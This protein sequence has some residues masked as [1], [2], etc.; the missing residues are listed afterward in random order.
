MVSEHASPLAVLGGVDAGG[1]NVHVADL[2]AALGRLGVEVVVHTRRDDPSLPRRVPFAPGVVVDHVDAGPAEPIPKDELLPH[3]AAFAADLA[4]R[5]AASRPDVVHAHFWMSGLAALRRRPAARHP[6]GAH[7]PR[8]RRGEAAP[9][10]RRRHQPA[11][12][13]RGRADARSTRRPRHR[14]HAPTSVASSSAMGGP[15]GADRG[16]PVRRRP[17]PLPPRRP[18]RAAAGRRHRIVVR[19]P[20][21]RAQGHRQRH[22]GRSPDAAR[23]RAGRRRRSAGGDARR[24][25]RGPAAAGGWRA[26]SA[27]TT[28]SRLL[29]AVAATDVPATAALGRRRGLLSRGTSR[30]AWSPSRPWPAACPWWPR[31]SAAWPRRVVDGVTGLL[32]PPRAPAA[33]ADGAPRLLDDDR[34]RAARWAAAGVRAGR[35]ATAGTG[36]PPR[37]STS[38]ATSSRTRPAVAG[39]SGRRR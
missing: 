35:S 26:S 25:P 12:P 2:A 15:T 18:G 1:Q 39:R 13:D 38:P 20:A 16:R 28:A 33:I 34:R 27:S 9:P 29:G 7:V 5:W 21:G 36:S 8:P 32:V 37:P 10:G 30:S 22:R 4:A 3:M 17:R 31:P 23:R 11:G 14:H 6:G 19:Q 24:R